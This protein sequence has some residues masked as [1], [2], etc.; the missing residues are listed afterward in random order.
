MDEN[1]I[2]ELWNKAVSE[3]GDCTYPKIIAR[4][5]EFVA[6]D[7]REACAKCVPS[8]WCDPMLTGPDAVIGKGVDCRPIE[9]VLAATKARI[10]AR[11][12]AV[13]KPTPD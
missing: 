7:E 1:R 12:N 9:A 2:T 3:I 4:F 6:A 8:N 5:A 11:S 10:L 13:G